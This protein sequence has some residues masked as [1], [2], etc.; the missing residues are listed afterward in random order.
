[1]L[2]LNSQLLALMHYFPGQ[3]MRGGG[4][5]YPHEKARGLAL[6]NERVDLR[7]VRT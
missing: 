7:N 3:Q 1:M 2:V 4:A 6:E 5:V